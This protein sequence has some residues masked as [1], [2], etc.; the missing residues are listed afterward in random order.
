MNP[1]EP[2]DYAAAA[3]ILVALPSAIW[4]LNQ[5]RAGAARLVWALALVAVSVPFENLQNHTHWYKVGWIPFVTPPVK[6]SD[7]I[8]NVLLYIPLG[9]FRQMRARRRMCVQAL[10]ESAVLAF[11]MELTQLYSHS[12]IPSST[13]LVCDCAGAVIGAWARHRSVRRP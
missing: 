12:R 2:A 10:G 6:A 5:K 11:L 7:I 9:Y 4:L 1:L 13:D 8:A 3:A